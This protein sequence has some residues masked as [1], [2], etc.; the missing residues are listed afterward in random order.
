MGFSRR[1]L[2]GFSQL[3]P[4]LLSAAGFAHAAIEEVP[5]FSIPSY[6]DA[7]FVETFQS[8]KLDWVLSTSSDYARQPVLVSAMKGAKAPIDQDATLMLKEGAKKYGLAKAFPGDLAPGKDGKTLVV[9][10]EVKLT[11]GLTCGGAYIKLLRSGSSLDELDGSTPYSIMFGPDHCGDTNKVHF[12]MQH[13]NPV[14]KEWEEKHAA[15]P[16]TPRTDK[17]S[18]I[19]TLVIRPDNSFEILVDLESKTS[20]S[21]LDDMKP[22][23]NPEPEIDDPEDAKPEDWVDLKKIKDPEASKPDDWDEDAPKKIP[24]PEATKPSDWLDDA[25]LVVPDPTASMP[26]DWDEEEDGEWEAPEVANPECAKVSGCG[27]WSAPLIENPDF[28]GKW[29]APLIP[30][31]EYKGDWKPRKIKNEAFFVDDFPAKTLAPMGA[32]AVEIWTM[33]GGIRMDNFYVGF[34]E[35]AAKAFA[36]GSWG[37]KRKYEKESTRSKSSAERKAER[38]RKR[39]KGWSGGASAMVEVYL[40]DAMDLVYENM[41]ASVAT[42]IVL[43]VSLIFLCS[44]GGTSRPAGGSG[45]GAGEETEL[46]A[47]DDDEDEDEDEDENDE[48]EDEEDEDGD[49]DEKK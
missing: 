29:A 14:S 26:D 17:D 1:H 36:K 15:A 43:L 3:L 18:H 44:F 27:E 22:P 41:M 8:G 9:Q 19:Y 23:V 47:K 48:D 42:A 45:G 11:E 21:L 35:N 20:G 25:P 40:G 24:D 34:D 32:V 31:P 30:N 46:D 7:F 28:K 13:Q 12:I 49:D 2:M 33:S 6:D 10:Y 5:E 38:E 16:P 4:F 37:L 39:A